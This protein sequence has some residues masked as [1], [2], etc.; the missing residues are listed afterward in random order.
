M[1]LEGH[2]QELGVGAFIGPLIQEAQERGTTLEL[3][4]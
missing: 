4:T 3:T 2:G 1:A